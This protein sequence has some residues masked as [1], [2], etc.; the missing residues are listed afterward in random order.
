M[1][2]DARRF[3]QGSRLSRWARSAHVRFLL[4]I[5]VIELCLSGALL[6]V[7]A[8]QLKAALDARDESLAAQLMDDLSDRAREMEFPEFV[9]SIRYQMRTPDSQG[10]LIGLADA[11]GKVIAGNLV[12]W[13]AGVDAPHQLRWLDVRH[14]ASSQPPTR[15]AVVRQTV[16]GH[17]RLIAGHTM[18]RGVV[19]HPAMIQAAFQSLLIGLPLAFLG[20]WLAIR[21][22]EGRVERI[23]ATA[24]AVAQGQL[25]RRVPLDGSGDSF[26]KLGARVNEMLDRTG[27]LVEELRTLSDS[28]AH[29]LRSPI[30]RLRVRIEQAIQIHGEN[31]EL[32]ETLAPILHEAT[33][34]Q[35]MLANALEIAR[36]EAGLA[37]KQMVVQDLA[38][39]VSDIAE[40]YEPLVED[41]G[42]A[43][44]LAASAPCMAMVHREILTIAISNL[45]DNAL[46]YGA[47]TIELGV[48]CEGGEAQVTV[49]DQGPGIALQDEQLALSRFGRLDDAR[50]REGAGL[51]LALVLSTLRMHGGGIRFH[52]EPGR[53]QVIATMPAA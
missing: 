47:G 18:R 4:L 44:A 25:S 7:A 17:Y 22:I 21:V 33:R 23:D 9:R 31:E 43:L 1:S 50:T 3:W 19:F 49:T 26:D 29:D 11:Q 45:I 6:G 52:R 51:G 37:K 8:N 32:A 34:L 39:V 20:A 38:R 2:G 35:V 42:R 12:R 27:A 36:A 28:L 15:Y 41:H 48:R 14:G 5:V 13:P 16:Y 10:S 30:M 46:K 24:A 40:L 53:F